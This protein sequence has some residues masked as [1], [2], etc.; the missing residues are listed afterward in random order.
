[1]YALL[2]E[3]SVYSFLIFLLYG[4]QLRSSRTKLMGHFWV[5]K[6][7]CFKA[8]LKCKAIDMRMF[9]LLLFS[10]KYSITHF[11]FYKHL[12]S[13]WKWEF[14]E[15]GNYFVSRLSVY[16]SCARDTYKIWACKRKETWEDFQKKRRRATASDGQKHV[17]VRSQAIQKNCLGRGQEVNGLGFV[18][19]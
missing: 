9:F 3:I 12:E 17:S 18:S 6:S 2:L 16:L 11:E 4:N 5:T 14:L 7:L 8:I 10:C 19:S 1:M 13:F 15:L